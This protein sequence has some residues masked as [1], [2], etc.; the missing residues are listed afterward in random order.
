ME[1]G[2]NQ[3]FYSWGAIKMVQVRSAPKKLNIVFY[4]VIKAEVVFEGK[5][6]SS[7]V[8][9]LVCSTRIY[10]GCH[11]GSVLTKKEI[12]EKSQ[13]RKGKCSS[14][15]F[16]GN[17]VRHSATWQGKRTILDVPNL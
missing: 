9:Y 7:P 17:L 14:E 15:T 5:F 12:N 4:R 3:Q 16:S 1:I 10:S 6:H 8:Q 13:Q 11:H 2:V